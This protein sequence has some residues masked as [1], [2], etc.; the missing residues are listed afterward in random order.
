MTTDC[1]RILA[2]ALLAV[3]EKQLVYDRP[4]QNRI[5]E[6]RDALGLSQRELAKRANTSG[7]Q[8]GMLE[9][10]ERGLDTEWLRRLAIA[11]ECSPVDLLPADM[12]Q[13]VPPPQLPAPPAEPEKTA[14]IEEVDVRSGAGGGGVDSLE[15]TRTD[16]WGNHIA[17]D[18]VRGEWG[19]PL[20]YV[21][22]ELRVA[23]KRTRIVEVIGDS[24]SPTLESGDR[25][26]VNL[27]DVA[28]SP[29]GVFVLWDGLGVV[30]K[31]LEYIPGSDP[32]AVKIISDN[33]AHTTYERTIEEIRIIGRAV[34]YGRR[35]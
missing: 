14:F 7:Q 33:P 31:R 29:G 21:R 26:M 8:I 9:R 35:M 27:A 18:D 24:M 5:A 32:I 30:V 4:M 16:E 2:N 11:L 23:P 17:T 28:P 19:I 22:Y 3:K 6:R 15:L 13:H 10:G 20:D 34:W 25:V 1:L 12:A